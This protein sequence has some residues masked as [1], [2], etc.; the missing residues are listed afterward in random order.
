MPSPIEKALTDIHQQSK[1]VQTKQT[2]YRLVQKDQYVGDVYSINY[3]TANVLI[4]E[5]YR[6]QVGGYSKF[7]FSHC[8]THNAGQRTARLQNRR[9]FCPFAPG[10]GCCNIAAR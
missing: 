6:Q 10:N 9:L 8:N 3:E 7:K 1:D 4:H 2:L 5:S